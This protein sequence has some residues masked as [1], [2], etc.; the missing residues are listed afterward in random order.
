M[1]NDKWESWLQVTSTL[2]VL[3]GVA[4][5]VL[6]LRQNSELIELQI[7]KQ[8]SESSIEH[9]LSVLPENFYEIRQKSIEDPGGLTDLEFRAVDAFLWP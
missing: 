2:A 8:D 6:Q 3:I 9:I 5:V 7:L 4:L 1:N